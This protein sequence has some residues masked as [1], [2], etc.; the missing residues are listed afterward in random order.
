MGFCLVIDHE[1]AG[2]RSPKVRVQGGP[3]LWALSCVVAGLLPR[4]QDTPLGWVATSR[5]VL[6]LRGL[7]PNV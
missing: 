3:C 6:T 5:H 1:G 4:G 7:F 2:A